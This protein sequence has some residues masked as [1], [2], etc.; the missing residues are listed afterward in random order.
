M[1]LGIGNAKISIIIVSSQAETLE[2]LSDI[3]EKNYTIYKEV[4]GTET[5]KKVE[6]EQP[7]L[8]LLDGQ[9]PDIDCVDLIK[10]LKD[11]DEIKDIPIIMLI[12]DYKSSNLK[13]YLLSGAVDYL[14]KPFHA[15]VVKIC[16]GNHVRLINQQ[17]MLDQLGNVD[18]LTNMVSQN[19]FKTKLDQE[20]RRAM[21]EK[22]QLSMLVIGIDDFKSYK[23]QFGKKGSED[24]IK[25]FS[26][27]IKDNLKRPMDLVARWENE[28][29]LVM[30]PSTHEMGATILAEIMRKA[31]EK[32]FVDQ[33]LFEVSFSITATFVGACSVP[34][35]GSSSKDFFN[36]TMETFMKI[37]EREENTLH[38]IK[39]SKL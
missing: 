5:I 23:E 39:D 15:S 27:V 3:L 8:I 1:N 20:W 11:F 31:I 12:D 37:R 34:E 36:N 32:N 25:S 33:N 29:F 35:R 9:M 16:I 6:K 14:Q 24:I 2:V 10:A 13:N 17:R 7:D 30:L 22:S 28:I 18:V 21:R 4:K 19:Y 26:K 38:M